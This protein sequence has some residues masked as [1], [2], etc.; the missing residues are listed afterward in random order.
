MHSDK[1]AHTPTH[2][3]KHTKW[4]RPIPL[5][6]IYF[7]NRLFSVT[8]EVHFRTDISD[9]WRAKGQVLSIKFVEPLPSLGYVCVGGHV[10]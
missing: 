1:S 6:P 7:D 8:A 4:R 10:S 9:V 2:T 5:N 3:H